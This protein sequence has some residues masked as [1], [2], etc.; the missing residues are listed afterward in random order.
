[1]CGLSADTLTAAV[2]RS[3]SRAAQARACGPPPEWPMTANRSTPSASATAAASL[4]AEATV[5]S[6][7]GV[8]P[9]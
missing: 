6:G 2:T 3:G 1:M 8:E 7:L 5:R 4:A 9:P